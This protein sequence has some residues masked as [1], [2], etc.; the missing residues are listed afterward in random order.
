MLDYLVTSRARRALLLRIWADGESG[1][2][3]ALARACGLSV[4]AAHRELQAMEAAGL[5]LSERRGAALEYRAERRHPQS[6]IL[7]A[8]SMPSD[9][10]VVAGAAVVRVPP[11]TE[12]ALVDIL[13]AS[14]MDE[15]VALGLPAVLWRQRDQMDYARLAREA[16]RRNERQSLGLFLQ[17]TGQ[18]GGDRRRTALRP[19]FSPGVGAS[20]DKPLPLARRWGYLMSIGLASFAE[21]FNVGL[22]R[23]GV[24]TLPLH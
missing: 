6:Q 20:G 1:S 11:W 21:A 17:L 13:I 3:S 5:A 2:V 15:S 10:D 16:T 14:H 24:L 19:Y 7:V 4:T 12:D 8:L 22:R 18:L 23:A 9:R